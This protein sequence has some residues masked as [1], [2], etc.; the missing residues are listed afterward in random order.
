MTTESQIEGHPL[1]A[2]SPESDSKRSLVCRLR[3]LT[4]RVDTTLG[5]ILRKFE[6][7]GRWKVSLAITATILLAVIVARCYYSFVTGFIV[8]DEAW[9]YDTFLLDTAPIGPYRAVF[10][11]VFLL[12]FSGVDNVWEFLLRGVLYSAI[13]AVGC[14][15]MFLVILRRLKLS[16]NTASMIVLSL[17]LFPVF[18]VFV[19]TMLTETLGLF[20]TL[21]G[22]YFCLRYVQGGWMANSLVSIVF[23]LLA[24]GVRESYLLFVVGDIILFLIVAIR[25]KS[26][27]TFAVYAVLVALVFPIPVRF[28]PLRLVQAATWITQ[29]ARAAGYQLPI[30]TT[31]FDVPIGATLQPDLLRAIVVGLGY[32]F[33]PLFALFAIFSVLV[34][35]VDL[36]RNKSSIGLFLVLN[37]VWS[38]GAFVI[39]L[40]VILESMHGALTIWT[41]SVIRTTYGALPC[42]I[43]FPSL[44]RRLSIRRVAALTIIVVILGSTQL[45]TVAQAFQRSLSL[46]PVDRLTLSYRA[47]YY[48][49]YQ[50]AERSGKVLIFGG[51]HMRE[52]RMYMAMAPNVTLVPVGTRNARRPL[53]ETE[54]QNWLGGNWDAIF[55][56]DDW[57]TI[58]IPG[59]A[60]AYPQF[61]SEILKS[62][63][64]PG[65]TVETLWIDGESYALQMIR[66]SDRV[67]GLPA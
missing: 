63:Q 52:I 67:A 40:E 31:S 28:E 38:F 46:E 60:D 39:P 16:E 17:P 64:Y 2:S 66:V 19:P 4:G 33:N 44:Y 43:G 54:F 27:G 59:G 9:Y 65:Y 62:R 6:F 18:I 47:P 57:Y 32:G 1:T 25:R 14:T 22:V 35:C 53:N 61:Y 7:L 26:L 29:S 34:V 5:S 45:G 13:W 23:F 42:I 24:Y 37:A 50:L 58:K 15:L 51:A 21:A 12:F 49:M 56:Y 11:A 36:L 20:L 30:L 48:R 8:P 3:R 55:L 10:H 41:S